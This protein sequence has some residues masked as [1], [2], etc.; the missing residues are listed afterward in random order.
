[1][2]CDVLFYQRRKDV[3]SLVLRQIPLQRLD[4]RR[5]LRRGTVIVDRYRQ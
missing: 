3:L 2:C 1:M 5:P 4:P